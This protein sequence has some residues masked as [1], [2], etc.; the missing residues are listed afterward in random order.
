MTCRVLSGTVKAKTPAVYEATYAAALEWS[1]AGDAAF[2]PRAN[3]ATNAPSFCIRQKSRPLTSH[4]AI[5]IFE[6]AR[7]FLSLLIA[8][9][10]KTN[11]HPND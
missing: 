4:S 9:P 2:L 7:L 10:H 3:F 11:R 8:H 1:R 6:N 5:I